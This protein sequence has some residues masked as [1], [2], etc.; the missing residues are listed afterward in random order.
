[1]KQSENMEKVNLNIRRYRK[2]MNLTLRE[3]AKK[4]DVSASFLSQ[5]ETGKVTPSLSTLLKIA[6]ALNTTI[7]KL[8]GDDG[9]LGIKHL[10]RKN[11]R[12]KIKQ[13]GS[14][15][16]IWLLASQNPSWQMEPVLYLF[17]KNGTTGELSQHYGQEFVYVLKGSLEIILDKKKYKLNEGDSFYF[18]S[19]IMHK[20][21]NAYDGITEVIRVI[22]PPLYMVY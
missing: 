16:E 8:L 4:L 9:D 3:L 5:V 6:N 14:G 11:E 19:Y 18:N 21:N 17:Y 15:L 22:V 1:M 12:K 7:G 20:F 2:K 10:V 13:I